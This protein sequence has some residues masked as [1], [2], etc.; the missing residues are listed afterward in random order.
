MLIEVFI[1][2]TE[3]KILSLFAMNPGRSFYGREICKKIEI[4]LGAAHAALRALERQ[5]ILVSENIGKTK[6]Y[7]FEAENSFIR[8]F[9]VLN[10]LLV[11]EPLVEA[12]KGISR[13]IVLF[14]SYATGTFDSSSDIDLFIVSGEREEMLGKIDAFKRKSKLD[15]RPIIK[16][17]VEWMELD[18]KNPEFFDELS[19]GLTL[20]EKPVEEPGL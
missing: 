14:G 9:K 10:T 17:Q 1:K 16:N 15:I 4:S 3:Q 20:W 12:T 8:S 6:L 19:R 11:L 18:R 13:R 7:R 5:G 2:S